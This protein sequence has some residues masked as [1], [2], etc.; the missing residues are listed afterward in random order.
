MP[1]AARAEIDVLGMVLAGEPRRHQSHDVHACDAAVGGKFLRLGRA[2]DLRRQ[3]RCKLADDVT[4]LVQLL[5]TPDVTGCPA[6]ILEILVARQDF[7][8]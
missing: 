6:R 1:D 8:D 4:Q 5:L 7:P 2:C 3:S